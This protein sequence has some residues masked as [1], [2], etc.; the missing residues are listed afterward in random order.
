MEEIERTTEQPL[1]SV[2]T[3]SYNSS[4]F[5]KETIK[6]VQAQTYDNWE[7]IIVDDKST[8]NTI[9][10]IEEIKQEDNRIK[11]IQLST[12]S[13]AAIARNT[14]IKK[15]KGRFIAFLDSDDLWL[16]TK[17]EQQTKFMLSNDYAFTFT[18]YRIMKE[19]GKKT[20]I[21]AKV[22][23]DID[24]NGLLKNTIIGCLT[25]MLDTTK[26]DNIEMVNIRTRQDFVL[27]LS[28]LKRGFKAYGLNEELALYRKVEG[29]ISSNKLKAA[30]RTWKVYREI[31]K[32]NLFKSTWYFINY[33]YNASVKNLIK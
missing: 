11:L 32:I 20:E 15:A 7:M 16:P 13:G 3:P 27:W 17:L 26:I 28:I 21:V 19:N 1:V 6:S 8:D 5:I 22:T 18:N 9:T 31:E 4:R 30:K 33:A 24:Y 23:K 10:I 29:S 12:N 25:V 2:I 14:A